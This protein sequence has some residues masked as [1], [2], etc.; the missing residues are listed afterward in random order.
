MARLLC[1]I[2]RILRQAGAK[3]NKARLISLARPSVVGSDF[4]Q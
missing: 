3:T 2:D 1:A 4:S